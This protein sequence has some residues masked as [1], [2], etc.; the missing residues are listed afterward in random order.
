M[1]ALW[2]VKLSD[3]DVAPLTLEG[4]DEAF[5]S[6][7]IDHDTMV[8]AAGSMQWA[9]LGALAGLDAPCA[10]NGAP[11]APAIP[12][13]LRPVSVD[14]GVLDVTDEDL[15]PTGSKKWLFAVTLVAS[16]F[17]AAA[18]EAHQAGIASVGPSV[19]SVGRVVKTFALATIGRPAS[20]PAAAP[21]PPPASSAA[22]PSPANTPIES[23]A[24]PARAA[25]SPTPATAAPTAAVA[26]NALTDVTNRVRPEHQDKA[27][28]ATKHEHLEKAHAKVRAAFNMPASSSKSK[29][30]GFTTDGNK[31]DP[32]NATIP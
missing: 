3:G 31:F 10:R 17:G 19:V 8:L 13:T 24:A 14:L 7:S 9:R 5:Q 6:G 28:A 15:K 25:A 26:Y 11:V 18:F 32:L 16:V 30:Q 12:N 2:Y 21:S 4:L 23:A 29:S 1:S 20:S 27:A 22:A